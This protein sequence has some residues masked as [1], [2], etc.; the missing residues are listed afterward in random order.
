MSETA[1]ISL[2][3]PRYTSISDKRAETE[4][5]QKTNVSYLKEPSWWRWGCPK[6]LWLAA[7]VECV[8]GCTALVDCV[9]WALRHDARDQRY[10]P[11]CLAAYN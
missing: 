11:H 8:K 9:H 7:L 2:K 10:F 6:Q 3:Y 4:L 1:W 5:V